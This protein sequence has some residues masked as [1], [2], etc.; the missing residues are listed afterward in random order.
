[1]HKFTTCQCGK[2]IAGEH[3]CNTQCPCTHE[4]HERE[5]VEVAPSNNKKA[6]I[7]VTVCNYREH[8]P[9]PF[10]AFCYVKEKQKNYDE[11]W[12]TD[13]DGNLRCEQCWLKCAAKIVPKKCGCRAYN[14]TASYYYEEFECYC[15]ICEEILQDGP[16]SICTEKH[17]YTPDVIPLQMETD[18]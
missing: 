4:L 1:M 13:D 17:Y 5:E 15:T 7:I 9:H 6:S 18:I 12:I 14:F 11:Q 2:E 8:Y 16:G 3:A 10:C